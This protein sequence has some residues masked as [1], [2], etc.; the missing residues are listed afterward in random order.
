MIAA[1][2]VIVRSLRRSPGFTLSAVLCIA[3]AIALSTSMAAILD[4]VKHPYVPFREPD[5]LASVAHFG[6]NLRQIT[7]SDWRE[8]LTSASF[9][10]AV[11]FTAFGHVLVESGHFSDDRL[12]SFVTPDYFSLLGVAPSSGRFLSAAGEDEVVISDELRRAAFPG[13]KSALG[14]SLV[15]NGRIAL[16]ATPSVVARH[17]IAESLVLAILGCAS[18]LLLA[19]WCMNLVTVYRPTGLRWLG[20]LDPHLSWRVFAF[21]AFASLATAFAAAIVPVLRIARVDPGEVL[22]AGAATMTRVARRR[23][24]LVIAQLALSLMLLF[25]AG[26]LT[27]S[28]IRVKQYEFGYDPYPLAKAEVFFLKDSLNTDSTFRDLVQQASRIPGVQSATF[29]GSV[30]VERGIITADE[31]NDSIGV[32]IKRGAT[33]VDPAFFRTVNLSVTSGRDFQY[34]DEESGA[35]IIDQE[36]A[37]KLW[38]GDSVIGRSL[39]LGDPR[40]SRPWLRVVGVVKMVRLG[41]PTDPGLQPEPGV[42]VVQKTLPRGGAVLVRSAT[43]PMAANELRQLLRERL[44]LRGRNYYSRVLTWTADREDTLSARWFMAALFAVFAGFTLL[45]SLAGI[46]GTLS[47]SVSRRMREF[48]VRSALGATDVQLRKLVLAQAAI[49]ILAATAIGGPGGILAARLLDTW[50]YGVWYS[51]VTVLVAAE[52]IL[53]LTSFCVCL[54]VMRRA[55]RLQPSHLLREL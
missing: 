51:D 6:G 28:A 31:H 43:P 48:G 12:V 50:L 53:M 46:Y 44:R 39:K 49:A 38:R 19:I 32:M 3:I 47:Y 1:L 7:Q 35:A 14:S 16:G 25:C 24:T 9:V 8:T 5:R 34:G 23:D 13:R 18:G 54:P 55:A 45:L 41:M 17:A 26:I 36:T 20:I 30:G 15:A 22:K 29:V 4:A 40:S 11:T 33:V 52:V 21:A 37:R 27:K 10:E 2:R 42:F